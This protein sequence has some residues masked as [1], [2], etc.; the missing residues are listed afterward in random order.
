ML[1][2]SPESHEKSV[3]PQK[4]S[5]GMFCM[6]NEVIRDLGGIQGLELGDTPDVA[7]EREGEAKDHT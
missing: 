4:R 3:R 6:S 5:D 2:H 7:G 1:Y